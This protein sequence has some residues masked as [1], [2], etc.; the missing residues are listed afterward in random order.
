MIKQKNT[1][2]LSRTDWVKYLDREQSPLLLSAFIDP[3]WVSLQK[4]Y[5]FDLIINS[6]TIKMVYEHFIDQKK[7]LYNQI[8]TLQ[9]FYE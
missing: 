6:I 2:F 7:N 3:Y 4:R 5:D 9:I 1:Q 8:F